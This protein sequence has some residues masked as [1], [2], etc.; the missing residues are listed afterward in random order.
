[1]DFLHVMGSLF[2]LLSTFLEHGE[3]RQEAVREALEEV[4]EPIEVVRLRDAD[5]EEMNHATGEEMVVP[6]E[7][8][9]RFYDR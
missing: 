4:R 9:C 1:M 8:A 3:R 5:V 7:I 6:P 2:E